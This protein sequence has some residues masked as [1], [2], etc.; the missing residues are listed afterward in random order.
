MWVRWK[1]SLYDLTCCHAFAVCYLQITIELE[2]YNAMF[3]FKI[4]IA[5]KRKFKWVSII[6]PDVLDKVL[7]YVLGLSISFIMVSADIWWWWCCCCCCCCFSGRFKYKPNM[8]FPS[9]FCFLCKF[10]IGGACAVSNY[11]L[12]HAFRDY[13]AHNTTDTICNRWTAWK[14]DRATKII[15]TLL[16]NDG[17]EKEKFLLKLFIHSFEIWCSLCHIISFLVPK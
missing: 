9:V 8:F 16:L 15:V 7:G 14:S 5:Y 17:F 13:H 12:L 11:D 4:Y 6:A 10:G 1:D 2:L 3:N